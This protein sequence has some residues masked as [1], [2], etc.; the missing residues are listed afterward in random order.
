MKADII[1][2]GD[3]IL[4]GQIVDTNSAWIADK[5]N[6]IGIQINRIVSISDSSE[7]IKQT[8]DDSFKQ[9][10]LIITTGGLGPTTDDITK[11]VLNSYFQGKLVL[12][13]PSLKN[14]ES[15]FSNRG[16]PLTNLNGKQAE[17]PDCCIPLLNRKGT[18]PGMWFNKHDRILISL[19]GVPFEMQALMDNEVIPRIKQFINNE[20]II[21]ET[22]QTF[23]LAESFLAEKLAE[24]EKLIPHNI[25]LAYLPSP[26]AIRLRLSAYGYERDNLPIKIQTLIKSLKEII[27]KYIFGFGET[28]MQQI[29]GDMLKKTNATLT[30]AESCTGGAISHLV[31]QIPGSSV[32]YKG[33]VVV[34]SNEL[35]TN[36][37]GINKQVINEHGAVSREVV[38]A[39]ALETRKKLSSD[40]AIA[41]S[42]IAGPD[43]GTDDKPVGTV[44]IAAASGK[45][46]ES[47]SFWFSGDRSVNILRSSVTALNMLRLLMIQEHPELLQ[48]IF[49]EKFE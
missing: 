31:T 32:F 7:S 40:Y 4:I 10:D 6:R 33:S 37:L 34:Y 29:V 15:I 43:G 48:N 9:V 28:T 35:K 3:E 24:W 20:V 5:L 39:M 26:T 49:R 11:N 45:S 41:T 47:K 25:K 44:W 22:I 1:T 27:P 23:G 14:I 46:L 13:E 42:G 12:H 18:A 2:I 19:P 38:E 36:I 17:V 30:I 8:I 16:L 21:H